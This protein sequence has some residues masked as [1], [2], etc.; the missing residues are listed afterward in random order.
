MTTAWTREQVAAIASRPLPVAPVI[1]RE[2][3]PPLISGLDL[4]DFWPVETPDGR[5][6]SV[7]G[8][9]L[10]MALSAPI[11]GDPVLR[12]GVA[13]IRLLHR[14]A[15]AWHD[16]GNV[17]PDGF[18][19]GSREWSGCAVLDGDALTLHFTAAG[20]RGEAQPTFEQRIFACEARLDRVSDPRVGAWSTPVQTVVNE[21]CFYAPA[22]E[23]EGIIG[24]IKAF[25]DPFFF[26]DPSDEAEYLLFTA[27]VARS[28]SAHNGAIG[29]ARRVAGGW[30][31]LP[32][33]ITA[34][35]VNNELERPHVRVV[36]G[37]YHLFWSTQASVFAP[38]GP[39]GPTGLYAMT[40]DTLLGG[41]MPFN[42]TG[43]VLAN[44]AEAPDQAY[45]WFV[46]DTLEA[47]AFAD[48]LGPGPRP[49]DAAAS[50][51]RFGGTLAPSVAL[52]ERL[53]SASG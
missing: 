34:D 20:R 39:A 49:S 21:G 46:T 47:V 11:M 26:R 16:L 4:W 43:L 51:R 50:R 18:S 10:W 22:D 44:P 28:A 19:P 27:S 31:L 52:A 32:P 6:A 29:I 25:R 8:G 42:G 23:V 2:Q 3:A 45:S 48:S 24:S 35:G 12:H 14:V 36:N 37:R 40:A 13:R 7:A 33:L 38:E 9:S 1:T 5:L 30:R 15:D 41:Y 53:G 17:M